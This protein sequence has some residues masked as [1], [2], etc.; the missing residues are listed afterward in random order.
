MNDFEIRSNA[1]REFLE[2]PAFGANARAKADSLVPSWLKQTEGLPTPQL[3]QGCAE[4]GATWKRARAPKPGDLLDAANRTHQRAAEAGSHPELDLAQLLARA[5]QRLEKHELPITDCVVRRVARSLI[6]H[7][8]V[9]LTH[10]GYLE[11]L[12]QG[13]I[14]RD[15]VPFFVAPWTWRGEQR[16]VRMLRD[17]AKAGLL[18]CD[19]K[20]AFVPKHEAVSHFATA[21]RAG[22]PYPPPPTLE[23][24]GAAHGA[25][26]RGETQ[27]APDPRVPESP[28]AGMTPIGSHLDALEGF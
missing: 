12:S 7:K 10:D 4:L 15:H 17:L 6:W 18:W 5:R 1:L 21:D 14:T 26:Q 8:S 11:A 2:S 20:R 25:L 28:V 22:T 9:R 23:Q 27:P 19:E 13:L 3:V 24:I 16:G